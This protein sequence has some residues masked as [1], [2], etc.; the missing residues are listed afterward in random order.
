MFAALDFASDNSAGVHPAVMDRL[1]AVNR[2][3]ALAY[4]LDFTTLDAIQALQAEFG[5]QAEVFPLWSGTAA[6]ILSLKAVLL[7]HQSVLCGA[8]SH[9]YADE[10]GGPEAATGCKME[11]VP[12]DGGK[13][14]VAALKTILPRHGGVHMTEPRVLSI[15]QATEVGTVYTSDEIGRL[16]EFCRRHNLLFHLDGARIANAA[17]HLETDFRSFT[18]DAGVDIVSFGGTK[19]GLMGAEA[20]ILLRPDLCPHFQYLQKQFAQLA[21]KMRFISAQLLAYL[22]GGLWRANAAHANA[23]ARRLAEGA[24]E[25]PGVRINYPVEANGV[26]ASLAPKAVQALQEHV[27]FHYWDR[28]KDEVRWMCGWDTTEA[29]V[30]AFLGHLKTAAAQAT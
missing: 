19:N 11:P 10:T 2:G 29:D 15:T 7:P 25:V 17:A 3:R 13:V 27:T 24:A 6:N 26:F 28:A 30:A 14:T 22:S 12:T 20:V 9:L 16:A 18:T 21:S 23:M 1:Q 5:E 4:G 8:H